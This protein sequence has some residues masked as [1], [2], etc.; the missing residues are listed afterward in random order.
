MENES[1]YNKAGRFLTAEDIYYLENTLF[2]RAVEQCDNERLGDSE[3]VYC[4]RP[5]EPTLIQDGVEY[6]SYFYSSMN[7][8]TGDCEYHVASEAVEAATFDELPDDQRD[9]IRA[10]FKQHYLDEGGVLEMINDDQE[11]QALHTEGA[12]ENI[13]VRFISANRYTFKDKTATRRFNITRRLSIGDEPGRSLG[14]YSLDNVDFDDTAASMTSGFS[15][16]NI[17]DLDNAREDFC[18]ATTEDVKV[19]KDILE[20]LD[21]IASYNPKR[22]VS[23]S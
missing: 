8:P 5:Q 7:L 20:S 23:G 9:L 16:E 3:G 1:R 18:V 10:Q 14:E 15:I 17:A 4:K 12:Y 21:L 11:W 13:T 6:Y 22:F 2:I 19:V